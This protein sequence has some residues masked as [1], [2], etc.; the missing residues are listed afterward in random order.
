[1]VR[2][3]KLS[4]IL[5]FLILKK[6]LA[7]RELVLFE[8]WQLCNYGRGASEVLIGINLSLEQCSQLIAEVLILLPVT[9]ISGRF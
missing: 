7:S 3:K 8:K 2:C 6:M 1:M 4:A 9:V 5:V